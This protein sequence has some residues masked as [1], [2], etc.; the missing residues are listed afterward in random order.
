MR[1]LLTDTFRK[2]YS[3][4]NQHE[5]KQTQKTI[6]FLLGNPAH[7][8][9]QVHRIK[10][11]KYWEAYVNKDIR[12]VYAQ[13]EDLCILHTIGHHDILRDY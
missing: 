8:S 11:T 1:I 9:L 2:G 5:K 7:P 13:E 6:R 3:R 12:M 10:G 4:L